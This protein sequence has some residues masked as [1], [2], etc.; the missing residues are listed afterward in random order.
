MCSGVI[1]LEGAGCGVKSPA[2]GICPSGSTIDSDRVEVIELVGRDL[3]KIW[4]VG[5]GGI[6]RTGYVGLSSESLNPRSSAA[7]TWHVIIML[8]LVQL[9]LGAYRLQVRAET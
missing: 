3:L 2:F 4:A 1:S 5:A 9:N 8:N 6:D 7:H